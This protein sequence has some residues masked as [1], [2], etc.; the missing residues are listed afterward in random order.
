MSFPAFVRYQQN[1]HQ[2]VFN[3]ETTFVQEGLTF[4]IL[5]KNPLIYSVS[6]SNF[7]GLEVF[8]GG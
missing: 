1:Y 8:L 2:K 4:Q 7:R 3:W 5:T 6:N